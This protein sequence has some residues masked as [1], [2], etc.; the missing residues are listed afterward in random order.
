MANFGSDKNRNLVQE[1][2]VDDKR[3][4]ARFSAS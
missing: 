3:R 2:H 4:G 1:C